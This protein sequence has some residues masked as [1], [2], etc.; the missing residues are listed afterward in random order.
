MKDPSL[1]PHGIITKE[2]IQNA[3]FCLNIAVL[4]IPIILPITGD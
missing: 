3:L 1:S 4:S 2:Y